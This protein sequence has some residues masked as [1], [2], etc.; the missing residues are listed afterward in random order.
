MRDLNV[1]GVDHGVIVAADS[2]GVE[3]RIPVDDVTLSRLKR[4]VSAPAQVR[5]SPRDIQSQLRAGLTREEV[6]DLTGASLDEVAR[7]EGPVLAELE[8]IINSALALPASS[9]DSPGDDRTVTV[10]AR[11]R[12]QIENAGGT[13]ERWAS[14]RNPAGEWHVKCTFLVAGIA[15]ECR[16]SFEPKHHQLTPLNDEAAN[17]MANQA[18]TSGLIPRL[19]AVDGKQRGKTGPTPRLTETAPTA[20]SAVTAPMES[21]AMESQATEPFA[22]GAGLE[23]ID[24]DATA[25]DSF[26]ADEAHVPAAASVPAEEFFEEQVSEAEA[27]QAEVES[28][29]TPTAD[30]MAALRKRRSE[31]Q[32]APSWLAEAASA[33]APSAKKPGSI[34]DELAEMQ[35]TQPVKRS[36]TGS[37]RRQ[38]AQMPTWD[39][40]VFGTKVDD[41]LI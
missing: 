4:P 10:G 18:F 15:H 6:A 14:W 1:T 26:H 17:L 41:D 28:T 12:T 24:L 19:R 2:D 38:R 3:Y 40:I 31:N 16:W 13:D 25:V 37:T 34:T 30:L 39:E 35:N 21:Q 9:E 5:V 32:D 36:R 23:S 29:P 20:P 22:A 33:E 11:V 8:Y 7:F 27:S